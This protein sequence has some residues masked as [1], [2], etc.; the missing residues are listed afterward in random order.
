MTELSTLQL[1]LLSEIAMGAG[2]AISASSA[3]KRTIAALSRRGLILVI[4]DAESEAA[5]Q[6][7]PAGRVA[8]RSG[9]GDVGASPT[10]VGAPACAESPPIGGDG[11]P[12]SASAKPRGKIGLLVDL[13]SRPE[14]ATI[15]KLMSAT[16]WQAHSVRGAISGALKRQRGLAA[17]SEK[18]NGVRVYRLVEV[19]A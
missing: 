17:T 9:E 7:T 5:L 3:D 6:I 1:D 2:G 14:G 8:I 18:N 16:G 15:E 13:L 10:L 4:S 11:S 12:S 19:V